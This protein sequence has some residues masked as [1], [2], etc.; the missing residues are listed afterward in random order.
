MYRKHANSVSRTDLPRLP[1]YSWQCI[2]LQTKQRDIDLVIP[3]D[4]DMDLLL[5]FLLPTMRTVDGVRNSA[6]KIITFAHKKNLD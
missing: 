1:F 6:S 3:D 2:T 4:K 5:K